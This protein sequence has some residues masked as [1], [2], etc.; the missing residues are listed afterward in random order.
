MGAILI[1]NTTEEICMLL[2][3]SVERWMKIQEIEDT[4]KGVEQ[5]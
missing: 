5:A 3:L 1:K 4:I 2:A